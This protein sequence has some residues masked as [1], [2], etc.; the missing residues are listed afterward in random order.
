MTLIERGSE[1]AALEQYAQEARGRVGRLVLIAGEAGAGKSALLEQLQTELPDARWSW[2][3]CDGLFT[4]APLGPLFDLAEQLGGDLLDQCRAGSPRPVLF[5]SLLKQ[6]DEPGELHVLVIEDVHWA[7]EATLDLLRF[8]GRRIRS[9]G[10]LLAVTYRDDETLA[11]DPL[12]VTLGDLA[13]QRSTRRI[14]LAPLTADAVGVLA[15]GSGVESAQLHRVTGGNPF[16]VR[17]VLDAGTG[18]LP[19]SARDAVLA[20]VARL[21]DAARSV[22]DIA[23]LIGTSIDGRLL[24]TVAEVPPSVLDELVGAGLLL[25]DGPL[26]RFRHEIARRAVEEASPAHRH[27]LLHA[28]ILAGLRELDSA[29]Y[30]QLAFHAEGAADADAVLLYAPR[31]ARRSAELASRREAAAQYERALRFSARADAA[32]VAGLYDGLAYELALLDRLQD[33]AD[34]GMCAL[35]LWREAGDRRREGDTLRRL[36]STMCSLCRGAEGLE[37]ARSAVVLLEPLGPSVELAAAYSSLAFKL[38]AKTDNAAAIEMAQRARALAEPLGAYDV[39]SEAL[40]AEGCATSYADGTG[41][42]LLRSALEVA[43]THGLAE[44]AGRAYANLYG[45]L[46]DQRQFAEAESYYPDAAAYCDEHDL[47]TYGLFLRAGR[48]TVLWQRGDWEDALELSRAVLAEDDTS[49]LNRICPLTRV[50][51]IRARQGAGDG[52]DSLDEAIESANG[53]GE[54]QYIVPVRIVRAESYWLEGD[55]AAARREAELA[56]DGAGACDQWLRGEIGVWLQRTGS[57]RSVGLSVAEPYRRVLTGAMALLGADDEAS[58]RDALDVLLDLDAA[59]V[60]AFTR[61]KMRR[62]GIASIPTG[63]RPT[64]RDDPAGL[65]RRQRDVLE[66]LHGGHTNAEIAV[67]LFISAKT[68]DHHVSA[69]L[70]KLGVA[71]RQAAA[72]EAVRRGLV[73]AAARTAHGDEPAATNPGPSRTNQSRTASIAR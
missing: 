20:R 33:A 8:L 16:F 18:D 66:L 42:E 3:A 32:T 9:A 39:L 1:L 11:G 37:F 54:P 40:N 2:G 24:E 63:P 45:T 59:A 29:N 25:G 65:T 36:A 27:R 34:A 57:E 64:T 46:C 10:V 21:S 31:A 22:L 70:A 6:V 61:R 13:T 28:Q 14:G 56:L 68:V 41:T 49:P 12:Q 35:Q 4:P 53:T 43:L 26:L 15:E 62:L 55:L 50:G 58:L 5:G 72:K 17:A 67:R 38:M 71:S 30:A 73:R 69:V 52:W 51:A 47:G 60:V 23:A 7:D 48:T 44:Q 19:P